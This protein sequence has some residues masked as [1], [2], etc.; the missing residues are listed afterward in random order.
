MDFN[1]L[2]INEKDFIDQPIL[3]NTIDL[4]FSEVEI[5]LT[6]DNTDVLGNNDFGFQASKLIW[7]MN[8]SEQKIIAELREAISKNCFSNEFLASWD[9]D[10]LFMQGNEKDIAVINITATPFGGTTSNKSFIFN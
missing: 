5:L 4:F 3:D 10:I 1:T 8:S 9:V 7:E 6:T 2:N